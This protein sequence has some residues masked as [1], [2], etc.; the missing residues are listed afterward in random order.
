[1][2][3]DALDR[4]VV[5]G[6]V[7]AVGLDVVEDEPAPDL[8]RPLYDRPNVRLTPHLAWYSIEARRD[9]ALRAAD[10]AFR[11]ISGERPRNIVNPAARSAP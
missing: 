3:L 8:T 9:L 7:G 2:D 5:S 4:A 10:E 6:R 1:V 11:F